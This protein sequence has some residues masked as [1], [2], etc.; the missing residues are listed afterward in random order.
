[1]LDLVSLKLQTGAELEII[2]T[3][4]LFVRERR[5]WYEAVLGVES[6]V[7]PVKVF[8]SPRH[9]NVVELVK[10]NHQIINQLKEDLHLGSADMQCNSSDL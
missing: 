9:L 8:V 5:D 3:L 2:L 4:Y 7:E 6:L 1:M 10:T